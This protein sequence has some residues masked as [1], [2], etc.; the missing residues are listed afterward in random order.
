MKKVIADALSSSTV[1][2]TEAFLRRWFT[3]FNKKYFNNTLDIIDLSWDSSIEPNGF[4][5]YYT[6]VYA[7]KVDPKQI[8]LNKDNITGFDFFRNTLVHEML[9]YYVNCYVNKYTDE[10]WKEAVILSMTKG[11]EA[12][13]DC[14]NL[15]KNKCHLG[16]W[17]TLAKQLNS[18]HKELNITAFGARD[19][20]L[21]NDKENYEDLHVIYVLTEDGTG[22]KQEKYKAY[23]T[24]KLKEVKD[25]IKEY[26]NKQNSDIEYRFYELE[27]DKDKLST[28]G[29]RSSI[30]NECFS[31]EYVDYLKKSGVIKKGVIYLGKTNNYKRFSTV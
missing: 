27:I 15:G 29:I 10:Q 11:R 23:T 3:Y 14:L 19:I 20:G 18:K 30:A 13:A 25:K 22:R 7:R 8:V 2:Y 1:S 31:S 6:D 24:D 16:N 5:E 26:K 4:F 21:T 17:A 9:H 28:S 12:V